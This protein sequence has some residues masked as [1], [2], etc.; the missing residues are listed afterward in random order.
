MSL[1]CLQ[2]GELWPLIDTIAIDEAQFFPDLLDF[3][4]YAADQEGKHLLVAGLDGDYMRRR[5]GQVGWALGH[6]WC[7][8]NVAGREWKVLALHCCS[9]CTSSCV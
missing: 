8:C 5:F 1:A 3:C 4:S 9:L 2:V 6:T 7:V